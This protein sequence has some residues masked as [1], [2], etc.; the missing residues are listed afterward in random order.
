MSYRSNSGLRAAQ[1][2]SQ[3]RESK[4]SHA[5]NMS[6]ATDRLKRILKKQPVHIKGAGF[7]ETPYQ[8][9]LVEEL[10]NK[11]QRKMDYIHGIDR[12]RRLY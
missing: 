6:T 2:D 8:R 4:M 1:N 11:P 12:V 3:M 5:S 9:M 7:E 10:L